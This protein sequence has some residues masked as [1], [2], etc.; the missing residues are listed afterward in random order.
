MTIRRFMKRLG[1]AVFNIFVVIL[2]TFL[3]LRATPGNVI[4]NMAIQYAKQFNI[5]K[6]EAM[7]RVATLL[8]YDPTEPIF[9][10]LSRYFNG[11][12]HGNLGFSMYYQDTS[13]NSI[14]AHSLPWTLFVITAALLISFIIGTKLGA[15]MA[16]K[17]K[18]ILDP[19]ISAFYVL[20]NAIP[21]YIW[22]MLIVLI[23][24]IQ[25]K[26]FPVNGLYDI[27]VDPGFNIAFFASVIYHAAMPIFAIVI[28]TIFSWAMNMK[29]NAVSILGE[30][31]ITAAWAR[32]VPEK[33]I[34]KYYVK[35]NAMLPLITNFAA[36]FGGYLGGSLF[37]ETFFNYTGF[38]FYMGQAIAFRDYTLMQGLLLVSATATILALMIADMIYAWLD[39]RVSMDD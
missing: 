17:H 29:S 36:S 33:R 27:A 12:M 7:R 6:Q 18:T 1:V 30:D 16:W 8:N 21:Y 34:V 15:I 10:Q 31:Y 32:G 3:L 14:V 22:P 9:T 4:D 5:T 23:F 11:L 28:T 38:G 2:V 13:V 19:I 35:K 25:L 20:T 24:C 37:I 39:P 26:W